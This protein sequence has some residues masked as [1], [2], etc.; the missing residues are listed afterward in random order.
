MGLLI[1]NVTNCANHSTV[2]SGSGNR[3]LMSR[4][5]NG[6]SA[7]KNIELVSLLLLLHVFLLHDY[8]YY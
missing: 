5:G 2:N 7:A 3:A 1:F 8:G 4:F 6:R